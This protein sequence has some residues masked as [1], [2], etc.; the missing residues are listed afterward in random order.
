M[1]VCVCVWVC[2][3]GEG[4]GACVGGEGMEEWVGVRVCMRGMEG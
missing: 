1:C 3:R 4:E 2:V